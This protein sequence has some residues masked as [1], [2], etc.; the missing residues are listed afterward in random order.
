MQTLVPNRR[1]LYLF[2]AMAM[3]ASA[4]CP[5][6][7]QES[8]NESQQALTFER[9]IRPIFKAMCFQCH[10]EEP[11]LKGKL[12][13][14]LVRLVQVGGESGPAISSGDAHNSLLWQKIEADE[15]PEGTKKLKPH[16]KQLIF[17]WIQQGAKTAR[18]E[19][20]DVKDAR[21]TEEELG[22]WAFQPI[23]K[24]MLPRLESVEGAANVIDLFVLAK[25]REH[26]LKPSPLAPREVLIRRVAFNTTGL[27]P[28]LEEIEQF[29]GDQSPDAV[30]RMIDRYLASPQF[31]VRWARHWL[32]V[33]GYSETDKTEESEI[34]RPFAWHYRDY[35][36]RALNS[37]LPYDQFIHEQLAGDELIPQSELIGGQPNRE[38]SKHLDLLAATGFLRMAPDTTQSSDTIMD[39]NQAVAEVINVVSTSL[40]GL[41]VGC[42]QCHDHRYDPV[43]TEDYYEMRAVFDPAFPLQHWQKPDQRL[44]D[45]TS[46]QVQAERDR[47][48]TEAKQKEDDV[49]ARTLAHCQTIQDRELN[50]SPAELRD[51]LRAAV[52]LEPDKRT[53]E[54]TALLDQHPRVK[55]IPHIMGLLIEYDGPA[56]RKFE[57]ELNEIVALRAT[58]PLERRI[59]TVSEK[60]DAIPASTVFFRGDP[61]SPLQA[62]EPDEVF[63]LNQS[64]HA[65]IPAAQPDLRTTGR[66]SAYAKQLTDGTHPL[67]ARVIV[68]RIWAHYFGTGIVDTPGDFGFAGGRPTHPELLD[69]LATEL[70]ENGWQLKPLHRMI[71]TSRT[72]QQRSR[73]DEQQ[74][75][76]DP[77][78]RW[79]TRMNLRRLDAESIR[80]ALLQAGGFLD[81]RLDGQSVPVDEDH[82]GKAVIGTRTLRD[83]LYAGMAGAGNSEF[84][85]SLFVQQRRKLP[86]NMLT[87]F[88]LPDLNPNC[89]QRRNTT[90]AQQSLWF[91]ND[92]AIIRYSEAMAEAI[93]ADYPADT[94]ARIRESYRRLF[95]AA[96]TDAEV[97][98]CRD[99]LN[100]QMS[101]L[102]QTS[103]A[104]L[105]EKLK[106]RPEL[107]E[108]YAIAS[109]CQILMGSNRFLYLD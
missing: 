16:E 59:M 100:E 51:Q 29:V 42:A 57:A 81:K 2:V 34:V 9:D 95:G 68:N 69:F 17:D 37:D 6:F 20:A 13:V 99:Y 56:Y 76:I 60:L 8:T 3:Q 24:P 106:S 35:V 55:P 11:E 50:N 53:P 105:A 61:R 10:G 102:S 18:P 73:R 82:E 70:M 97:Q 15:M 62:V 101:Q 109:L 30:E 47:I 93:R 92:Q 5:V 94:H 4:T 98:I 88:D 7:G 91:L 107:L 19:P 72:F 58:K 32:D 54:Q 44:V 27:A 89:Q 22:F 25:Q 33:A 48:E 65:K 1:V 52:L 12:D 84:R 78:N 67:I 108:T 79:L 96:P 38:N 85:R 40:L 87:T 39:R 36:I 45:M 77:E 41:T 23:K 21:F 31:G 26:G 49:K 75:R 90:V 63:V 28:T 64:R 86:L 66:R 14:R 80:D 46:Q 104:T 83:G 74:D 43:S 71:M 103:D